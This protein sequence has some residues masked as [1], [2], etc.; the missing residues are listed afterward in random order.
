MTIY[1]QVKYFL[2]YEN[3]EEKDKALTLIVGHRDIESSV[4]GIRARSIRRVVRHILIRSA[5]AVHADIVG[6]RDESVVVTSS[7][8][9]VQ[10]QVVATFKRG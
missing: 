7:R 4:G 10:D 9:V 1:I 2:Y 3:R 6:A 5:P 8:I